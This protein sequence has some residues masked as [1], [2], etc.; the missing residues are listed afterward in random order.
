MLY[1]CNI[2]SKSLQKKNG[3]SQNTSVHEEQGNVKHNRHCHTDH[4]IVSFFLTIFFEDGS[5]IRVCVCV[6]G[7]LAS[8]LV[9]W[10]LVA[11]APPWL[12]AVLWKWLTPGF[13][14]ALSSLLHSLFFQLATSAWAVTYTL[15]AFQCSPVVIWLFTVQYSPAFNK[16]PWLPFLI[17]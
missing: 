13:N 3:N 11:F 5:K 14:P 1:N 17:E 15:S 9:A 2:I 4:R 7:F 8:H 16:S 12:P 6:D 10:H